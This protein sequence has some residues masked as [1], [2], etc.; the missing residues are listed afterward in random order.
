MKNRTP[1]GT[2]ILDTEG[3]HAIDQVWELYRR[4]WRREENAPAGAPAR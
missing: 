2:Q 4:A 1:E 3:D